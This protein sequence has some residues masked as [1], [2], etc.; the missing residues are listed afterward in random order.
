MLILEAIQMSEATIRNIKQ[1][2]F[3]SF[4]YNTIGFP[5]TAI[6]LLV[7]WIAGE[8]IAFS[9]VSVVLNTLRLKRVKIN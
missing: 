3:W 4:G 8:T 7:P 6:D 1:N 5:I 2:L 9:S